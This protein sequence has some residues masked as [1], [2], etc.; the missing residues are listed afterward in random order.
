MF[1][2][3][4]RSSIN[5]D[6][7]DRTVFHYILDL[8]L[9]KGKMS[10]ARYYLQTVLQRLSEY[11]HEVAEI[12]NYQ[13]DEGETALTLAAKAR[14]KRL[15]RMLI[16]A[17][18]SPRIRNHEGKSAEDYINEEQRNRA[19]SPNAVPGLLAVKTHVSETA[20]QTQTTAAPQI[21]ELLESLGASFDAG[22][23]PHDRELNHTLT[24]IQQLETELR[25]GTQPG[26]GLMDVPALEARE[27][28]LEAELDQR[29]AKRFRLGYDKYSR[30]EEERE[31]AHQAT[32]QPLPP[33][34]AELYTAPGSPG[35][36]ADIRRDLEQLQS[37]REGM[38]AEYIRR[39]KAS[40]PEAVNQP[41]AERMNRLRQLVSIGTG[42]PIESVDAAIP[43]LLEAFEGG[44][45]SARS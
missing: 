17:G 26:A 16:E 2:L 8:A 32:G 39:V 11:P 24:V 27:R 23:E 35:E 13:D 10:A 44:Q 5:I 41:S 25:E 37:D 14:S 4:H 19:D 20:R 43:N 45:L 7:R 9:A 22:L 29:I 36:T 3:L 40:G 34:L 30:D 38:F 6:R 15:V 18:A 31:R 28:E 12:L 42:E 1:E 21:S 33:D